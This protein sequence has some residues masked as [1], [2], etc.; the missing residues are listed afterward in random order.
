M[1][2]AVEARHVCATGRSTTGRELSSTVGF[3]CICGS[4]AK[5]MYGYS[6]SEI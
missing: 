3:V 1:L 6:Y 5:G 2:D 4:N